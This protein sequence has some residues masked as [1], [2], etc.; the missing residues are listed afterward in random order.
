LKQKLEEEVFR[1]KVTGVTYMFVGKLLLTVF[2]NKKKLQIETSILAGIAVVLYLY[3][4]NT[5]LND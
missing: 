5:N 2:D 4:E 3:K 1:I